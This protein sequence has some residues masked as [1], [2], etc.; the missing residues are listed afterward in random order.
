MPPVEKRIVEL[1]SQDRHI[2][3]KIAKGLDNLKPKPSRPLSDEGTAKRRALFEQF[4]GQPLPDLP[5]EFPYQSGDFT[6]LGP[7][8]FTDRQVEVISYKGENFYRACNVLVKEDADGGASHCVKRVGHPRPNEHEDYDG[9][10][11]TG[12]VDNDKS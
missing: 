9:N 4:F 2:L 3:E 10:I 8:L 6:V 5:S 7:E 11:I 1:S 12:F